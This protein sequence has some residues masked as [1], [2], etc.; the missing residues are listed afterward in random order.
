MKI[1]TPVI[2]V[3]MSCPDCGRV[4]VTFNGDGTANIAGLAEVQTMAQ[5]YLDE[6]GNV[7]PPR[8]AVVMEATCNLR[9]CRRKRFIRNVRNRARRS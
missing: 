1:R 3:P 5:E 7:C 4:L 6:Y 2:G 9:R 8:E